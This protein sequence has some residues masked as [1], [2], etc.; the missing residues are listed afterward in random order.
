MT[1]L[2]LLRAA[3]GIALAL[4]LFHCLF[5]RLFGWPGSLAPLS[6]AN[7]A[8]P[9]VLNLNLIAV[10]LLFGALLLGWTDEL[11]SLDSGR[12]L[13]GGVGLFHAARALLQLF[14][15]GLKSWSSRLL[16]AACGLAA[17]LH[18]AALQI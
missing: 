1:A 2:F 17:M 15:L 13:I 5:W 4:A 8:L 6:P 9:Q 10:Y 18:F 16:F 7:R 3:G 12:A 14:F 11:I